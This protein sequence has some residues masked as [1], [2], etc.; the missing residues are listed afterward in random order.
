MFTVSTAFFVQQTAHGL[1]NT[2]QIKLL[3]TKNLKIFDFCLNSIYQY[4]F[5]IT[6]KFI[7]L[8]QAFTCILGLTF[9][10]NFIHLNKFL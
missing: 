6:T 7:F 4:Q 9:C 3:Q 1:T 5:F 8:S 2:S 10:L